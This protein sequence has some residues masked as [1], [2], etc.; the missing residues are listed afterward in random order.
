MRVE[1][2][3]RSQSAKSNPKYETGRQWTR[4][5]MLRDPLFWITGV[6]V[7]AP[8]FIGTSIFFHQDYLIEINGWEPSLYYNSFALMAATTV[9]VSLATGFAIDRWSAVRS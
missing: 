3:P 1:R 6:G 2:I 4:A 5:E 7:F 9:C 8:A